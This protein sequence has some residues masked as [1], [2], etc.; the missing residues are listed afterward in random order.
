LSGIGKY[1][2]TFAIREGST[3]VYAYS[4]SDGAEIA[5]GAATKDFDGQFVGDSDVSDSHAASFLENV[6]A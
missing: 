6:A 4:L 5:A 1:Y 2:V 3:R